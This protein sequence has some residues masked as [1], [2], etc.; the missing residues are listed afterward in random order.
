MKLLIVPMHNSLTRTVSAHDVSASQRRRTT[1]SSVTSARIGQSIAVPNSV[2]TSFEKWTKGGHRRSIMSRYQP[3]SAR[4]VTD[5]LPGTA[6]SAVR[7][8]A[9]ASSTRPVSRTR[10]RS[11]G[12]GARTRCVGS[13]CPSRD[14]SSPAMESAPERGLLIECRRREQCRR[15][16]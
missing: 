6:T 4:W 10:R 3:S 13:A 5:R 14:A 9:N 15:R 1:M 11:T 8:T 7:R 12:S 16:R 2:L